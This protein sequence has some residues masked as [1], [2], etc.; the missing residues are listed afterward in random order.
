MEA[1]VGIHYS[2]MRYVAVS[3]VTDRQTHTY[4]TTITLGTSIRHM[5]R[6]LII[7]VAPD[8]HVALPI[9]T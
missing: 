7:R 9:E 8:H 5:C 6:G 3:L 1:S 4:T 2:Q